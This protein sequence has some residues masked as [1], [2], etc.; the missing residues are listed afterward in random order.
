MARSEKAGRQ[1][2][3][4]TQ[5]CLSL[6]TECLQDQGLSGC[7][8]GREEEGQQAPPTHPVLASCLSLVASWDRGVLG[9]GTGSEHQGSVSPGLQAA[10]WL[11][12]TVAVTSQPHFP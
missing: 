2:G 10:P 11:C 8:H 9:M 3:D 7:R 5:S 1:C 6:V 12:F 4:H